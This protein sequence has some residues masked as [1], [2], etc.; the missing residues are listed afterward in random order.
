L[1]RYEILFEMMTSFVSGGGEFWQCWHQAS[2]SVNV[3]KKQRVLDYFGLR[4]C[5]AGSRSSMSGAEKGAR[6]S[7]KS[8][9]S[10][11][12]ELRKKRALGNSIQMRSA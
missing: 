1:M 10:S 7:R 5:G 12:G 4:N 3:V 6:R 11:A 2:T 9:S 8:S